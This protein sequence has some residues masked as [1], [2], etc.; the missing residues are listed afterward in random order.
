MAGALALHLRYRP[1]AGETAYLDTWTGDIR[2]APQ[3]SNAPVPPAPTELA[4]I[5]E[6]RWEDGTVW[7][8]GKEGE[9]GSVRFAFPAPGTAV[10]NLSIR[11]RRR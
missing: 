9:C 5:N 7:L 3:M 2:A 1:L 8:Y 4:E 6:L 10:D 11:R